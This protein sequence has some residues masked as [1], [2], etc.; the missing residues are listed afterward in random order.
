MRKLGDE[1]GKLNVKALSLISITLKGGIS[2]NPKQ[3][4]YVSNVESD[5]C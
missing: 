2:H 1:E 5:T 3:A 4:G